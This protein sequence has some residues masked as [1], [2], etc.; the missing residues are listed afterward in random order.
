MTRI[1]PAIV[2]KLIFSP[3]IKQPVRIDTGGIA[4]RKTDAFDASS[5][6]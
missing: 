1:E 5:N 3:S 6:S 2:L 4:S